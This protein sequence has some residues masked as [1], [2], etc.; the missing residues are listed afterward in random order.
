MWDKEHLKNGKNIFLVQPNTVSEWVS[1][2]QMLNN[3]RKLLDS[4]AKNGE[5]T[6]KTHFNLSKFQNQ[7][8]QYIGE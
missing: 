5:I 4:V 7:L 1:K 8:N 3:D 2:I 6:V